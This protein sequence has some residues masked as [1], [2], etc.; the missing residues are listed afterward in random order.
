MIH[1][2][3]VTWS[4]AYLNDVGGYYHCSLIHCNSL[5][6]PRLHVHRCR[7]LGENHKANVTDYFDLQA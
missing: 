5:G 6:V 1:V 2:V 4:F 3:F 7:Q